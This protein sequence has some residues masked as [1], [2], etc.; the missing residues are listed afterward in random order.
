LDITWTPPLVNPRLS[1]AEE[2][3]QTALILMRKRDEWE[4][5]GEVEGREGS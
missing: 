1:T 2:W 4:V 3:A 5:K